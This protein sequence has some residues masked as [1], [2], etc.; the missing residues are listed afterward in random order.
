MNRTLLKSK[1]HRATVTDAN[2]EYEGSVMIDRDLLTA[3]DIVEFEQVQIYDVTNGSRLTTYAIAGEAGS[4]VIS[5]QG[6]A[7]HLV[8]PGD[9]VIIATYAA[10]SEAERSSHRPKL[11][12][13]D[14]HNRQAEPALTGGGH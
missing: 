5:V 14:Q 1:I 2:L 11:V 9:L 7:A 12:Y 8:Q 3:A 4:G 10:Y 6:A 13:V